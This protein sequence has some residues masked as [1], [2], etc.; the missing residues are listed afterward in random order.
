M[1]PRSLEGLGFLTGAAAT[2]AFRIGLQ[3][4]AGGPPRRIRGARVR[5]V[6]YVSLVV[7]WSA[8]CCGCGLR[9]KNDAPRERSHRAAAGRPPSV[10]RLSELYPRSYSR[11]I[12]D[13]DYAELMDPDRDVCLSLQ[14]QD[15]STSYGL[16]ING[17]R[18]HDCSSAGSVREEPGFFEFEDSETRCVYRVEVHG[19]VLRFV[20][21]NDGCDESYSCATYVWIVGTEIDLRR[22]GMAPGEVC[23]Y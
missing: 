4:R 2:L 9:S 23:G 11:S 13:A 18:D 6:V 17:P 8:L 7:A 10:S 12:G 20:S 1:K 19:G 14:R 21:V 15:E 5:G 3:A 16:Y 22:D